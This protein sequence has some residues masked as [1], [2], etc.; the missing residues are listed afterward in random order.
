MPQIWCL[1][2]AKAKLGRLVKN[3]V[4]EGP[5]VVTKHGK[6]QVVVLSI[7]EYRRLK[8]QTGKTAPLY[9]RDVQVAA[10]TEGMSEILKKSP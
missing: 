5:Q 10:A 6:V 1:Q 3:A 2:E 4:D 9:S 8:I 7:E